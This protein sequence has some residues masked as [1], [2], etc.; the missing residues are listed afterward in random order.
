MKTFHQTSII[1]AKPKMS[2]VFRAVGGGIC[3]YK[4][5]AQKYDTAIPG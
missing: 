1:R 2:S 3:F 5:P 4:P